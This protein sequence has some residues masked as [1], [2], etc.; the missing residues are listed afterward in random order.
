MCGDTGHVR[1]HV[2][3]PNGLNE[4]L[5]FV[6]QRPEGGRMNDLNRHNAMSH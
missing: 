6:L 1:K 2:R 5:G 3:Q 4:D